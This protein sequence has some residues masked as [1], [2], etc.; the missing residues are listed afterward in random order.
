MSES[1][2]GRVLVVDEDYDTLD[3]LAE[4]MRRHGHRVVLAT[5]GRSGLAHAVEMQAEVVLVD[6]DVRVLDVRTFVDV[7]TE[8][9]R[10]QGAHVFVLGEGDPSELSA[11]EPRGEPIVKPFHAEEVA[12]RVDEVVRARREPTSGPELEGELEQ[13]GAFDLLQV[14]AQSR[15][16]GLLRIEGAALSGEIF[17]REGRVVSARSNVVVA[18][19]A[20]FRLLALSEGQFVFVPGRL[21]DKERIDSGT[22]HLLMEAVRRT[23]ERATLAAELPSTSTV[24]A[25]LAG[26]SAPKDPLAAAIHEALIAPKTF[27]EILDERPEL[28]L[29]VMRAVALLLRDEAIQVLQPGVRVRLCEPEEE[30]VV[31]G[32]MV[33]MRRPGVEGAGRLGVT[34]SAAAV[35]RFHRALGG[36]EEFF[37]APE[38]PTPA[39][40][41][42]FG[43]LGRLRL[44]GVELEVFALPSDP[45]LRPWWA[46][47]LTQ[48][49]AVL[50]L[51]SVEGGD[52]ELRIIE[53]E[54]VWDTPAGATEILRAVLAR[55]P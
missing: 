29:E 4:A 48:G 45:S 26:K 19:K 1:L 50:A 30:P 9:P 20:L 53:A 22:D 6:R 31:R 24:L 8:N 40:S 47:F 16:T 43:L 17:V 39:G 14:F 44:G 51:E 13:V 5:D 12:A 27:G 42:L 46:A 41:G 3:V 7:L 34:G 52:A 33:R 18:E 25:P 2:E 32:A 37:D 23:D 49:R 15:R 11:L 55:R 38:P 21:A 10:T 36:L 54:E 28:D 35:A